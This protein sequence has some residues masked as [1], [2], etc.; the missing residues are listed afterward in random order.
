V[1]HCGGFLDRLGEDAAF[2]AKEHR[3]RV[4]GG[5]FYDTAAYDLDFL[6]LA[7]KQRG[8]AQFTFGTEAPGSGVELRP[9]TKYTADDLIPM[10][11]SHPA[12][13]FMSDAEKTDILHHTPARLAPG[14]ADAAAQ[15]ARARAKAY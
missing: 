4:A 5:L 7:I 13:G 12:L 11:E 8:T 14:L 9:G 3:E 2:R 15:N 1:C 10:F 6:A